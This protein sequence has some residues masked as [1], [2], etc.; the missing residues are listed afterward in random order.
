MAS[1]SKP[2]VVKKATQRPPADVMKMKIPPETIELSFEL[3]KW[4]DNDES[5]SQTIASHE[6]HVLTVLVRVM[7]HKGWMERFL[8]EVI[9]RERTALQFGK[10]EPLTVDQ[11]KQIADAKFR[12]HNAAQSQAAA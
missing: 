9:C 3:V 2:R 8:W 11:V 10:S 6:H 7:R 12:E 4:I 5:E 1:K